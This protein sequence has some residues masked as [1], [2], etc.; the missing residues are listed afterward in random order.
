MMLTEEEA[1][2]RWCPQSRIIDHGGIIHANTSVGDSLNCCGSGCM[3]WRWQPALSVT[4]WD[5]GYKEQ[6]VDR[7]EGYCGLAGRPL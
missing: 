5:G 7:K 2:T 4:L 3:A 6:R 1:A